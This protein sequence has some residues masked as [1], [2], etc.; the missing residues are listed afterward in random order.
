MHPKPS[1]IR[2]RALLDKFKTLPCVVC[3]DRPTDPAHIR[4]RGAGGGDIPANLAPLCRR[5][6]SMQHALGSLSFSNK[7]PAFR[8]YLESLGWSV[9]DYKLLAPF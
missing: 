5:H 2:D 4:S 8:Y 3:G 7:F 6:H 9:G 1:R